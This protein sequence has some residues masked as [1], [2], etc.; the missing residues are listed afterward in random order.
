MIAVVIFLH[1]PFAIILLYTLTTDD[2]TYT[3]PPPGLTLLDSRRYGET[4]IAIFRST[5]PLPAFDE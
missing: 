3:F 4:M 2:R 5:V 1:F